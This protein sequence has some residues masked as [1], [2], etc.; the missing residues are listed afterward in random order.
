M[1]LFCVVA[2]GYIPI[3]CHAIWVNSYWK[4]WWWMWIPS[5]LLCCI[6]SYWDLFHT[7]NFAIYLVGYILINWFFPLLW[8]CIFAACGFAEGFFNWSW[9]LWFTI[10]I[11]CG[12]TYWDYRKFHQ[13]WNAGTVWLLFFLFYSGLHLMP[14]ACLALSE[15]T[16]CRLWQWARRG[17]IWPRDYRNPINSA[18]QPLLLQLFFVFIHFALCPAPSLIWLSE[19]QWLEAQY[20]A[21]IW[22]WVP[23]VD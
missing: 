14:C 23:P 1:C 5:V 3:P 20:A 7:V 2:C 12:P 4:L 17:C 21:S 22:P 10:A 13:F 9:G 18:R 19:K 6:F 15:E 11:G 16:Y 8:L